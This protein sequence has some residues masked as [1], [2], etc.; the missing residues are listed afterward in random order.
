MASDADERER[1]ACVYILQ[2][3]FH[4]S[5]WHR[6]TSEAHEELCSGSTVTTR[7][8]IEMPLAKIHV[9]DGQYDEARLDRV[10][11]AIQNGLIRALGSPRKTSSRSF[12]SC[13]GV[14]SFTRRHSWG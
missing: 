5:G 11:S 3:A 8:E 6:R 2:G 13:R 12:M 7:E 9:L 10:S 14:D 4:E 1:I